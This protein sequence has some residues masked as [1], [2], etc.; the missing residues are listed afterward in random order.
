M[1]SSPLA[2]IAVVGATS[3]IAHQIARDFARREH[4]VF[5][6]VGRNEERLQSIAA[7]LRALGA[8]RCEIWAADLLAPES[9][10]NFAARA[11]T[12]LGGSA[13][14]VLIA[15][16]SLSDEER[17]TTDAE[18]ADCEIEI[19]YGSG[20]RFINSAVIA[21]R[22]R[23]SG[24]LAVITSVAGERGRSSNAFYAATK[25]ALIAYCSGLR[26]RFSREGVQVTDLRP[27]I[28]VTP[29]TAHLR[30][31]LLSCA[32]DRAGALCARAIRRRA[33]CAYIP[34]RW[35]WIML[36]V[37]LLPEFIFKRLRF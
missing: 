1:N 4:A 3:A 32:S 30:H 27:G 29:M 10:R 18:Y 13:D 16:G 25:A 28:I 11:E 19:N 36:I 5:F 26:A 20:V 12:A 15:H 21:M 17:A 14:L 35:R 6:L 23:K 33:D 24:Q 37:R 31:G 34:G 2:R 8:G 9:A 22:A 7:D